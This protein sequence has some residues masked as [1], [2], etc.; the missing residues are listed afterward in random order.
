MAFLFYSDASDKAGKQLQKLIQTRI[1][2][3]SVEVYRTF[4]AIT[5][6]LN[7]PLNGL[8]IAVLSISSTEELSHILSLSNVL[9]D[10]RSILI[11]PDRNQETVT[12]GH[13]LRPRFLTYADSDPA[14][15]ITVLCNMLEKYQINETK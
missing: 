6:R 4:N 10:M 12:K 15:V 5:R 14:E 3:E 8:R 13:L 11:L 2:E 9:C 1:P 7:K